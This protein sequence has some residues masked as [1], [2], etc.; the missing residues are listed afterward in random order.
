MLTMKTIII[1]VPDNPESPA[2]EIEVGAIVR[3]MPI[4]DADGIVTHV[5]VLD[6]AT[7][8]ELVVVPMGQVELENKGGAGR[9]P[10]T[11]LTDAEE[12]ELLRAL[13]YDV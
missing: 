11:F 10:K 5:G 9:D 8:R 4:A 2:P 1:S 13:G 7:G 3:L 12:I 6:D